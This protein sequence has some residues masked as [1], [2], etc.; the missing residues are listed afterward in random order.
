MNLKKCLAALA[1]AASI[2]AIAEE[3]EN[4][5]TIQENKEKSVS[6]TA[7]VGFESEFWDDGVHYM[8]A[9]EIDYVDTGWITLDEWKF[10]NP[11]LGELTGKGSKELEMLTTEFSASWK[12]L[13]L[14]FKGYSPIKSYMQDEKNRR[15]ITNAHNSMMISA[16]K[17]PN[18][19]SES[20]TGS[21][22]VDSNYDIDNWEIKN[23]KINLDYTYVFNDVSALGNVSL[24]NGFRYSRMDKNIVDV[25]YSEGSS[26]YADAKEL[27]KQV[28]GC[29]QAVDYS[30]SYYSRTKQ[31][32]ADEYKYSLGFSLDDVF[33]KPNVVLT[34]NQHGKYFVKAGIRYSLPLSFITDKLTWNN[35][36]DIY[37]RGKGYQD[38]KHTEV[39]DLDYKSCVGDKETHE[40]IKV[41]EQN[42]EGFDNLV[43]QTGLNYEINDHMNVSTYITGVQLLDWHM[44]KSVTTSHDYSTD[45]YWGASLSYTF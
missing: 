22:Y 28:L 40:D 26:L 37:Y 18:V 21:S 35:T 10:L 30:Y 42:S 43:I 3:A 25:K 23:F 2:A 34:I 19:V 31:K 32:D 45:F 17:S 6:F 36:A 11:T 9:G 7:K 20:V 44:G 38:K 8:S 15:S 5:P 14:G 39:L 24:V 12:G 27:T 1:V 29:D 13:T 41:R 16:L 4:Q 33:L